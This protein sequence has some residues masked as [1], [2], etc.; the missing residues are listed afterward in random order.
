MRGP[1]VYAGNGAALRA[2]DVDTL[3]ALLDP[4]F[5]IY[6]TKMV[7]SERL[8]IVEIESFVLANVST[9]GRARK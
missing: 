1:L 7:S 3:L 4:D 5:V 9:R 6:P 8:P 2:G